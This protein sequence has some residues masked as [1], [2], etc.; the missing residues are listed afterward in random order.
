MGKAYFDV[1]LRQ[2]KQGNDCFKGH[3]PIL[4]VICYAKSLN[5]VMKIQGKSL[6]VNDRFKTKP[7]TDK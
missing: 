6:P 1:Q 4:N 5:F 7:C 2:P 3:N